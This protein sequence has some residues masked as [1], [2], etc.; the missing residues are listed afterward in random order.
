MRLRLNVD[1]KL[2][3]L[4]ILQWSYNLR[5]D[6]PSGD[7]SAYTKVKNTYK[8]VNEYV[9]VMEPLF[10]LECWQQIQSARDTVVE[11][12]FEILVGTR[13]SVDGFY[14]V[15]TSMSKND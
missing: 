10:M 14:D 13:T 8:D 6:Y 11:D 4:T 3:Y 1:L 12:P 2:L 15:F 5:N 9:S 7:K